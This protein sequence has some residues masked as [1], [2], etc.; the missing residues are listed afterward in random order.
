MGSS[1]V[2]QQKA[3][4]MPVCTVCSSPSNSHLRADLDAGVRVAEV[5]ENYDVSI[6]A[7]CRHRRAARDAVNLIPMDDAEGLAFA[8]RLSILFDRAT[9][10]SEGLY[11][12]G[13]MR[14][15][16]LVRD[17][18]LRAACALAALGLD[19]ERIKTELHAAQD[20]RRRSRVLARASRSS[21]QVIRS[22]PSR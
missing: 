13:D 10:A 20:I 8:D 22:T 4:G 3:S 12:K 21:S 1:S 18:S 6:A 19:S 14:G 11:L 17:H 5:A 2:I 7:I 16:A 15:G 9:M